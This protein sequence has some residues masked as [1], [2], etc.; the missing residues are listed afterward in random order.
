ME[1][2]QLLLFRARLALDLVFRNH[3]VCVA[4]A[5]CKW[6]SDQSYDYALETWQL[7]T[8]LKLFGEGTPPPKGPSLW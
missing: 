2:E 4:M 5:R 1:N 7:L 6:I 8:E 3:E